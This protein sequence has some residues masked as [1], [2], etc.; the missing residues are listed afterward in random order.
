MPARTTGLLSAAL[1]LALA[2]ALPAQAADDDG[3]D[4]LLDDVF[5][6]DQGGLFE[7]TAGSDDRQEQ[8][9]RL[10]VDYAEDKVRD[11][12]GEAAHFERLIDA[13]RDGDRIRLRAEMSADYGGDRRSAEVECEVDFEGDNEVVAFRQLGEAGGGYGGALGGDDGRGEQAAQLCLEHAEDKVRDNGGDDVRLER[14]VDAERDG[15]KV[16]LRADMSADYDGDR[17]SAEVECEVD[18]EGHNEVTAFRQ[19]GDAGGGSFGN[20]VRDLLGQQ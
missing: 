8:A 1:A 5:A 15:D 4:A 17:R 10:C 19:V 3:L 9:A 16:R 18:F 11:N 13:E 14:V 7:P 12:G 6:P 20:L 2:G